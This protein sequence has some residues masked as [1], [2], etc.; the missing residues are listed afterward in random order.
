MV[1]AE[2]GRRTGA[3]L[4]EVMVAVALGTVVVLLCAAIASSVRRVLDSRSATRDRAALDLAVQG[5]ASDVESAFAPEGGPPL[6]LETHAPG[7]GQ[8]K[9]QFARWGDLE[10]TGEMGVSLDIIW[11]GSEPESGQVR[12]ER[13]ARARSGPGAELAPVTT[14]VAS[15]LAAIRIE[16]TDGTNWWSDWPPPQAARDAEAATLPLGMR[17]TLVNSQGVPRTVTA[18]IRSATAVRTAIERRAGAAVGR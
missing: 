5:W 16:A 13:I 18:A 9:L 8:P 4:L 3:T 2:P 11:Q 1:S 10:P 12:W 14:Q 17:L 15:G 6:R 7:T